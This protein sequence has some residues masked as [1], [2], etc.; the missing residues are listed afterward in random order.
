[1]RKLILLIFSV[2]ALNGKSQDFCKTTHELIA[3][4]ANKF[5]GSKDISKRSEGYGWVYPST[6]I[7]SYVYGEPSYLLEDF[8]SKETSFTQKVGERSQLNY[9]INVISE[10]LAA[11]NPNYWVK[12]KVEG[13]SMLF[14][15]TKSKIIVQVHLEPAYG[16]GV[17]I[18][19]YKEKQPKAITKASLNAIPFLIK[20]YQQNYIFVDSATKLPIN[21]VVYI[22]GQGIDYDKEGLMQ[23]G[24]TGSNGEFGYGFIDRSGRVLIKPIAGE[25]SWF[26]EGMAWVKQNGLFFFIDKNAKQIIPP[27]YEDCGYHFQEGL[28]YVVKNG[29]TGYIDKT[30]KVI[31]PLIYQASYGFEDGLAIIKKNNKWGFINKERKEIIAPIYDSIYFGFRG[32]VCV[33]QKNKKWGLIDK[34]GKEVLPFKL[35]SAVYF[36]EGIAS[37]TQN[38]LW[39][40]ID[41]TGKQIVAPKYQMAYSFSEGLAA[42]QRSSKWGFIDKTGKEII[43]VKYN[44]V[45]SF[46]KN[47]AVVSLN[48][49]SGFIDKTGKVV[50]SL[51]YEEADKFSEG[52]AAVKQNG[53]YG[54]I[55]TS[56]Q[57][58]IS[59][60]YDS[61]YKFN[62]GKAIVSVDDG[63]YSLFFIDRVGREFRQK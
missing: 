6:Y 61:A 32:E 10:C 31:I 4:A 40:F 22:F 20:P 18:K 15:N 9:I 17:V 36:N 41:K 29:K 2:S 47:L 37:F 53:K 33:V 44:S 48:G 13:L 38:K 25:V 12:D 56:G 5:E 51:V 26:S 42:V 52:L 24:G 39:G 14:T 62:L 54:Y 16:W 43:P 7:F 27:T 46:E 21:S 30:G 8:E 60:I 57:V 23:F 3:A 19:V 34:T 49:K 45:G 55:D 1:M 59:F 11:D 50:I 35:N 28:C 58:V 63:T